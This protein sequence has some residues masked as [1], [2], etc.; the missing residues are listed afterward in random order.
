MDY[1][2]FSIFADT[3]DK[4]PLRAKVINL[5]EFEY[6]LWVGIPHPMSLQFSFVSLRKIISTTSSD[7]EDITDSSE[8]ISCRPW[9]RVLTSALDKTPGLHVYEIEL[10]NKF[11]NDVAKLYFNYIVQDDDPP[12]P[13]NYMNELR[14]YL[15]V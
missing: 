3:Y 5:H 13:Y 8:R 10:V 9:I 6:Y 7:S 12:K 15:D 11:T 1:P 14:K 4:L 2:S